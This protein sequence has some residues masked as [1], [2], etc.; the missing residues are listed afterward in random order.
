MYLNSSLFFPLI[1]C[2]FFRPYL[3]YLFFLSSYSSSSFL[4]SRLFPVLP[5]RSPSFCHYYAYHFWCYFLRFFIFFFRYTTT[6]FHSE[7]NKTNVALLQLLSFLICPN[8]S[9]KCSTSNFLSTAK[10]QTPYKIIFSWNA[11]NSSLTTS[12]RKIFLTNRNV[13]DFSVEIRFNCCSFPLYGYNIP[14]PFI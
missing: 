9:Y 6:C 10:H 5:F 4:C 7:S 13:H 14:K 12:Y 11:L 1:T 2:F 3:I 8:T